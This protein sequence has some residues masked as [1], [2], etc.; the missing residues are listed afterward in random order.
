MRTE[1]NRSRVSKVIAVTMGILVIVA[2]LGAP[3]FATSSPVAVVGTSVNGSIVRVTVRNSSLLPQATTVSVQAV[4][5]DTAIWSSVPVVLLGGQTATVSA[6][7][8]ATVSSVKSVSISCGLI[9]D[10]TPI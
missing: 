4:V 9:E 2:T 7:F 3:A 10:G 8:T 5:G 1:T 6:G